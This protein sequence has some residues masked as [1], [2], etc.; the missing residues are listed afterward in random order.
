MKIEK[1]YPV[2]K[3]YLWGGE[4]LKT[5]YGKE[6][7]KT[8]CAESWE[9]SFHPDGPTMLEDGR[10]LS[11][12]VTQ[13]DLGNRVN[14]FPCF[15]ILIKFIDAKQNLS[16]Q[17]HPSD[18]YAMKNEN[19]LGKTEMWYVVEAEEDAGIFLGFSNTITKEEYQKAILENRLTEYLN[20]Y[21]V[22][23]GDCFF[24]PSGTVHAICKGCLIYEIQENSNLTYRV[25]D[26]GRRDKNG[27]LRELHVEKALAVSDLSSY[28]PQQFDGNVLGECVYFRVEKWKV[29]D[30]WV[31]NADNTSFHCVTCLTGKGNIDGIAMQKGDSFF[32]PAN[33]GAYTITGDL[34]LICTKV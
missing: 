13:A 30:K 3:D 4:K 24:I 6:T 17:V 14:A 8:P 25:Y 33:Y 21:P 32:I 19:S 16:I 31:G 29:Q 10:L 9:L 34:E 12:V 18:E 1:L 20:F 11:E 26:Y 7:D 27:N 23:A 28:A 5:E 15:P 2:C 22:K